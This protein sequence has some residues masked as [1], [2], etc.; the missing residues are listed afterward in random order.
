M[1]NKSPSIDETFKS[2]ERLKELQEGKKPKKKKPK[3]KKP[4]P[5]VEARN[6]GKIG[7]KFVANGYKGF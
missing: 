1:S 2:L 3:A 7:D 5:L 6:G 4:K